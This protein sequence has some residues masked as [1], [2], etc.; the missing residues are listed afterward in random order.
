MS[1]YTKKVQQI[2]KDAL[3]KQE[4]TAVLGWRKKDFWW[5]SP[6]AFIESPDDVEQL[7]W[8][9]FSVYNP[10]KFL[11]D[12]EEDN[13]HEKVGIFVKGCDSRGINRLLQDRRLERDSV[14]VFGVPC[15]GKA[16]ADKVRSN[17][18]SKKIKEVTFDGEELVINVDGKEERV[19]AEEYLLDK[20]LTCRHPNPVVHDKL[21]WEEVPVRDGVDEIRFSRVEN[22]EKQEL[23][24]RYEYWTRQFDRCIRC[25]ACRNTCP[26]C[27]C[28]TCVFDQA[29]PRWIGKASDMADTLNYHII[30]AFH[31]AGRC[32]ECGECER[33]CPAGIPLQE[34]NRKLIKDLDEFFGE[35]EAGLDPEDNPPLGTYRGEDP[36]GFDES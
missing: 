30:R 12:L 5:Q 14:V 7:V 4:V 13:C 20:C 8:D 19:P 29:E 16:D 6:V 17:F 28:R 2:A 33:I 9:P 34:L 1:E 35:Y 15:S 24:D 22:V 31:V 11:L 25:F 21:A 26:A 10:V 32:Y 3:E 18:P 36:A 23:E 27:N